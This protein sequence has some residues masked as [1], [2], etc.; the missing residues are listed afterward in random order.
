VGKRSQW[1]IDKTEAISPDGMVAAMQPLAA[2]AGVEML[3]RGGNAIDAAVATAL[4]VGVVEPFMSGLGGIAFMTYRDNATGE[5]IGLDGS[6]VLPQAI[7][8]EM[9]EVLPDGGRSGVYG[10]KA[11]KDDAANT[12]WLTPGVPGM[13]ALIGE[14]HSRYGRLPWKDVVQPAIKLAEDGYE[15]NH[16]IAMMTSASYERLGQFPESRKTFFKPNGAPYAPAIGGPGDLFVQKDLARTLKLVAEHGPDVIYRGEIAQMI[17]DDMAANGGLITMEDLAAHQTLDF[18]P[19][20]MDYRGYQIYGQLPNNGYPTV[21]E[22]LQILEGFDVAA[23]GFQSTEALHVI[24]ESLRR[25]FVDRLRYL[26][27]AALMPVPM[28]GIISREYAAERR[29]TIDTRATPGAEPGDPWPFDPSG[30]AWLPE[31]DSGAG[32]GQTTHISVIDRDH[33]MVSL[34]STL[35]GNFGSRVVIKGTGITLNNATMWFDPEPGSV[36]SIGPGK[37]TMSAAS[38]IVMLK[39]GKPFAAIG[40]PG[41]RRVISA[42]YQMVVNMVDYGL[43]IQPAISAPRIHSEGRASEI[44]TRIP[45][46]VRNA[47]RELGHEVLEREE[48]LANNFFARPNGVMVN[49]E[50]GNLHGGAFPYTPATAIGV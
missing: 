45:E 30:N 11:T 24:I 26:G 31:R 7:R 33:N 41:G 3:R 39:D 14:A 9:F 36:T 1:L 44:S 18:E 43:S 17:A 21:L 15:F 8:P 6:T 42:V 13:P 37:R 32:E 20:A 5:T 48:T 35:G 4:A 12:G 47:L 50:T 28:Q 40:S 46:E 19:H 29:A 23:L 22:A 27:D 16:Y 49:H 25:A 34:T 38:Q 2:E 10:W